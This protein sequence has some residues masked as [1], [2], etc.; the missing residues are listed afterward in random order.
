M[1]RLDDTL[2]PE[3]EFDLWR[4]LRTPL[5]DGRTISD[6]LLDDERRTAEAARTEIRRYGEPMRQIAEDSL[7]LIGS[8]VAAETA[9]KYLPA[10]DATDFALNCGRQAA[11][12]GPVNGAKN[13]ASGYLRAILAAYRQSDGENSD[14]LSQSQQQE[15]AE[16]FASAYLYA[17]SAQKNQAR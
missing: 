11:I 6:L 8:A 14:P 9:R 13:I 1:L 15:I 4:A 16:A 12:G 17:E 10:G 3:D 5:P 7:A 2:R